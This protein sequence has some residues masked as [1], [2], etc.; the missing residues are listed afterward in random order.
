MVPALHQYIALQMGTSYVEIPPLQ[1]KDVSNELG[2]AIPLLFLLSP[3]VDP[4]LE[5]SNLGAQLGITEANGRLQVVSLGQ[6]QEAVAAQALDQACFAGNWVF[7]QNIHFA[8]EWLTDLDW[9]LQDLSTTTQQSLR[10]FLSSSAPQQDQRSIIPLGIL[11]NSVKVTT[12]APTSLKTNMLRALDMFTPDYLESNIQ[13]N[14]FKSIVFALCFFHAQVVGR[15]SYDTLGWSAKY[16]FGLSD[17]RAS[18]NTVFS[19]LE[20]GNEGV[21]WDD[22]S[23][24]IGEIMYGGHVTD[25]WDQRVLNTYLTSSF[26]DGLF[27]SFDL[28]A[29]FM[30]PKLG[31]KADYWVHITEHLPKEGP[32]LFGLSANAA[33]MSLTKSAETLFSGLF[34]AMEFPQ[35]E[36]K[37]T[38]LSTLSVRSSGGE[39]SSMVDDLSE[40]CPDIFDIDE[41]ME[42]IADGSKTDDPFMNVLVQELHSLNAL[43]HVMKVSLD[44]L[45]EALGGR[46]TMTE[47]LQFIMTSLSMSVIPNAW[48]KVTSATC[49]GLGPWFEDLLIRHNQLDEW[50]ASLVFPVS[51]WLPGLF[52]P[53]AFLATVIQTSARKL[54]VAMDSMVI[55][56][57]VTRKHKEDVESGPR[58]GVYISGLYLEGA[59]FD[60]QVGVLSPPSGIQFST[61]LH[62]PLA[63]VHVRAV[64][65][66]GPYANNEKN[67]YQCPVY[68]T[69]QRG[70]TYVFTATLKITPDVDPKHWILSGA[71]ILFEPGS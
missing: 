35:D 21:M 38:G 61:S 10:I 6:G 42:R 20:Q 44:A 4:L 50:S 66:A 8:G 40:R 29:G 55:L 5:V 31:S 19:Y 26:H 28:A 60:A 1:I 46:S 16:S 48:K 32:E 52:N 58:D 59:A 70:T 13:Q 7:L 15:N 3:G 2:P 37:Q 33:R 12:E 45:S 36:R 11:Q 56:T 57:D 22:L 51:I 41:V 43:M 63:L 67:V 65:K 18:V 39:L 69:M 17:L 27:E 49:K 47:A 23:Y 30:M 34:A 25:Q 24:L 9:K 71:A 64:P 14:E 62:P 53:K 68:R 54:T